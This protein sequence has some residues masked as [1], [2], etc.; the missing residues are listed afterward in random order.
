MQQL[1]HQAF[2]FGLDSSDKPI[3][4]T[5]Q[6]P[7]Q[8]AAPVSEKDEKLIREITAIIEKNLIDSDFNVTMLQESVGIGQKLLYR[9]IKQVT[10]MTP[11]EYI[12][13]IRLEKAARLLKEGR[14]S[15]SE[16]MYMVGFT[17]S[18]YFSK[19]F[20]EAYGMTPSAYIKQR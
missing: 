8:P 5:P 19:C 1:I 10:G 20:Q 17:K 2:D 13:H 7:Q 4:P 3:I 14:F 11:V 12:R 9:K 18:G 15:V 16:V 6:E